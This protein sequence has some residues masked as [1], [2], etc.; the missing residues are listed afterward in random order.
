MTVHLDPILMQSDEPVGVLLVR[1]CLHG[2]LLI[3]RVSM[4]VDV[5][6]AEPLTL[7]AVTR[8]ELLEAMDMWLTALMGSD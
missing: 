3:A 7:T 4:S 8:Q 5:V 1:A 2:D 6:E